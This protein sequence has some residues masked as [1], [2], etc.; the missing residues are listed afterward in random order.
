MSPRC[1]PGALRYFFSSGTAAAPRTAAFMAGSRQCRPGRQNQR[2]PHSHPEGKLPYEAPRALATAEVAAVVEDYR[3][4]AE[5]AKAAGF[6]GVEIHAANGYLIDQFLQSKT[7]QRADRYG[8]SVENRCRFLK[9]I[10]EAIL[11]VWPAGRVGVRLSPNG[12]F[13]DM[14]APDFRKP[15]RMPPGN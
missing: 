15:S 10:V 8:G 5:R 6:D 13:N 7:N 1:T 14:S 3:R 2:R 12:N 11:T 4:A 9:E